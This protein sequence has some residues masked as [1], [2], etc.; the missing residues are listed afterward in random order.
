MLWT[1]YKRHSERSTP[2]SRTACPIVLSPDERAQ[3][4][5]LV[6]ARTSSQQQAR[7]AQNRLRAAQGAGNTA[8]SPAPGVAPPTP[9][10]LP[11]PPFPQAPGP[12]AG[13]PPPPPPPPPPC[14]P[15]RRP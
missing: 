9:Q 6:R 13:A 4:D 11:G 3:L 2:M 12:A 7:R 10:H 5:R 15:P 14:P 1:R 8:L